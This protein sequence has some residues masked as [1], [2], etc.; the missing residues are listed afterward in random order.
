[1]FLT[2]VIVLV[3]FLFSERFITKGL[4]PVGWQVSLLREACLHDGEGLCRGPLL[5]QR[6]L[7]LFHLQFFS[8]TRSSRIQLW[9]RS[10]SSGSRTNYLPANFSDFLDPDMSFRLTGKLYCKLHFD[11]RNNGTNL[12]RTSS[13]RSVSNLHH[14]S[15][16][17]ILT[18][19]I[20][21]SNFPCLTHFSPHL[22]SWF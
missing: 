7:S 21:V 15:I 6:V 9:R 1:M 16:H 18:M 3:L 4:S 5:P 11:Q 13:L 22:L 17:V 2:S 20:D 19:M 14:T 10:V 12:R 8:A